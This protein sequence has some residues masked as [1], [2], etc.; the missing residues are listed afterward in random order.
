MTQELAFLNGQWIPAA[1]AAI[2]PIDAGFVQGT[3][4]AEQLRTFG[5]RIFH[6]DDHLARL[7]D[8]LRLIDV[9]LPLSTGRM[10]DAAQ[11]LVA[12]NHG[13]LN[14]GDDLG[15][16]IF[17]T[18][19]DYPSYALGGP[20]SPVVCMHTYPL[21]FRLWA[22]KYRQ[23][24]RLA[25]TDVRQVPANCWPAAIKCRSRM[26]YYL[27]DK[28]AAAR[29]PGARAAMLDQDGFIT[30][31]TT[32]NIVVYRRDEGLVSPPQ[33]KILHGISLAVTCE[34]A[35]KLGIATVE[36]DVTVDDVATADEVLLSSTPLSLLPVTQFN[37]RVVG[38]GQP[39]DVFA[40]LIT[41]W[42]ALVGLDIIAQAEQ[43]AGR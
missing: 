39:G 20:L 31:A 36:R 17:V 1:A 7:C 9:E 22:A 35:R 6:L 38:G 3:T 15:L 25:T 14:P 2:S 40:R 41:A 37:G 5:G 33:T 13:L 4:I 12:N 28:H 11:K 26:H 24:Q 30:E 16:S 8:S 27:A 21:P 19:G 18:P 10:A 43:F 34:L 32:A 23:G 29:F 42:N